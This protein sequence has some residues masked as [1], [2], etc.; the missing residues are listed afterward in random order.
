[1]NWNENKLKE[2]HRN[3]KIK[4]FKIIKKPKKYSGKV[5]HNID[6]RGS[7]QKAWLL[8]NLQNWANKHSLTLDTEYRFMKERRWEFDYAFSA[9]KIAVEYEGIFKKDKG[10]T[11]HTSI[12]GVLRDIEKYNAAML[13]GWRIIRVTAK[14]YDT[15]L[16]KLD[17][18]ME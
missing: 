18:M 7:N 8:L 16:R 2:L 10:K 12:T 4:G 13:L 1:M 5:Q 11:G 17:K 3:G 14:D 15:V 6:D 9:V